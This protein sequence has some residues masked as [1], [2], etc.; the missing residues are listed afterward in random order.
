MWTKSWINCRCIC[1]SLS[2]VARTIAV[3][4]DLYFAIHSVDSSIVTSSMRFCCPPMN[5]KQQLW[6]ATNKITNWSEINFL[7]R[8]IN[9]VAQ[10][11]GSMSLKC[12]RLSA[13]FHF[14]AS[15]VN[16]LGLVL[17]TQTHICRISKLSSAYT[18]KRKIYFSII[19]W[20]RID[21]LL[22]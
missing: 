9:T 16:R 10:Q 8:Q 3:K 7:F 13:C 15:N 22:S 4:F 20:L 5:E 17:T 18:M 11:N 14:P 19:T 1:V 6:K 21:C 12:L 2:T